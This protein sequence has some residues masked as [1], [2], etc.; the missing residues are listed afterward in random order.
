MESRVS[1]LKVGDGG[2]PQPSR[3]FCDWETGADQVCR[4]SAALER[5]IWG[6]A[7]Q[8]SQ[9]TGGGIKGL[10]QKQQLCS[11]VGQQAAPMGPQC[12]PGWS[13]FKRK[14]EM[15]QASSGSA[16]VQ[17]ALGHRPQTG[18]SLPCTGHQPSS[19]EGLDLSTERGKNS[20][21]L[22]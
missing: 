14:A 15:L 22:V 5:G 4:A 11:L 3:L 17:L 2:R 20:L 6:S 21:S 9:E 13:T 12:Y 16:E 8:W 10:A 7:Q 18:R 19:L 1:S